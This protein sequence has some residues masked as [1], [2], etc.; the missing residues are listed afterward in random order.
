MVN[1]TNI[2]SKKSPNSSNRQTP[3]AS[4]GCA[5]RRAA[6]WDLPR[7]TRKIGLKNRTTSAVVRIAT[8]V[9]IESHVLIVPP[10]RVIAIFIWIFGV[11][12][13][14]GNQFASFRVDNMD[15]LHICAVKHR[16]ITEDAIDILKSIVKSL[17]SKVDRCGNAKRTNAESLSV[18][19]ILL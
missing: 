13:T 5:Q 2:R 19:V 11:R 15:I 3:P 1:C 12:D 8:H 14:L 17:A 9:R 18:F 16:S 4:A 10:I 6:K 7:F